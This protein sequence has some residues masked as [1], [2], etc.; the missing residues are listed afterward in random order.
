MVVENVER[1][2]RTNG[3][4]IQVCKHLLAAFQSGVRIHH[5]RDVL[6]SKLWMFSQHCLQSR[7]AMLSVVHEKPGFVRN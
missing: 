3:V 5:D 7:Q 2:S 1:P 4:T 6:V